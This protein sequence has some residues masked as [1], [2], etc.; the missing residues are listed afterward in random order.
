MTD[1]AGHRVVWDGWSLI[2]LPPDWSWS[3][4]NGVVTAS[5]EQGVGALQMSFA[6]RERIEPATNEEALN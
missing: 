6:T 2:A 3:E 5:H 1:A 4:E